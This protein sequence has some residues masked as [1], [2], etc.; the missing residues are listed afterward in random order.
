MSTPAVTD[1]A[2]LRCTMGASPGTLVVP[3]DRTLRLDRKR[4]ALVTDHGAQSV[5]P[6][7]MCSAP[8]NPQ[9]AA[10]TAAA[11]GVL[12]PQPCVPAV[13]H[14]G[15]VGG[16]EPPRHAEADA[17]DA[18]PGHRRAELPEG[19]SRDELV[20]DVGAALH[21]A[22]AK[23]PDDVRVREPRDGPRL[24]EKARACRGRR[25]CGG[26]ELQGHGPIEDHVAAEEHL[27]HPAVP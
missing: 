8:T 6:F 26:R 7:G 9:V 17:R 23:D 4:L 11:N 20:R 13:Q 16:R 2:T 27:P 21:L 1:G 19:L 5:L 24:A 22:D 15:G 14:A 25:V 12:T 18:L 3:P 10:A